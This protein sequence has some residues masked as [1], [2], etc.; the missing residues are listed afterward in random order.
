MLMCLVEVL[1]CVFDVVIVDVLICDKL[2][3]VDWQCYFGQSDNV[4]VNFVVWGLVMIGKVVNID[5]CIDGCVLSVISWLVQCFGELVICVV[6][7]QV[8]KLM[9]KQ[10]V[11]GWIIFEVLKNGCLCCEQGYIYFFDMFGEVVLIVV[12]VEKYMVDYC[13]VID[14]VGVEL[15]VGLGLWLLILIKFLVLYLCYEVV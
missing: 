8:M 2:F 5:E 4:L 15:Q 3:V 7:N 6:M 10:F 13:Q 9:G 12:D 11:F 14:I 1:L